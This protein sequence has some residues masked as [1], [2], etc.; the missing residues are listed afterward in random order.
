VSHFYGNAWAA[1]VRLVDVVFARQQ[2]K[3]V[4]SGKQQG[5]VASGALSLVRP[6]IIYRRLEAGVFQQLLGELQAEE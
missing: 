2:G 1:V 6:G 5:S 3:R 4:C